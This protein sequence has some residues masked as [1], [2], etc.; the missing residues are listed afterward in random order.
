MR[1]QNLVRHFNY[2][3][4]FSV[5]NEPSEI[6]T[7]IDNRFF[8]NVLLKQ[9]KSI[10]YSLLKN[11]KTFIKILSRESTFVESMLGTEFLKS[12]GNTLLFLD[13]I[14]TYLELQV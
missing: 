14:L 4:C 8:F 3:K 5:L 1:K 9:S 11:I 2:C 13:L 10:N 12:S 7:S 6:H